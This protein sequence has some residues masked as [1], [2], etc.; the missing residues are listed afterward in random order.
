MRCVWTHVSRLEGGVV[1]MTGSAWS[2]FDI[3]FLR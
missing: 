3:S 1:Q 2:A